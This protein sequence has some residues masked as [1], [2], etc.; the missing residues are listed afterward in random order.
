MTI[1]VPET[2]KAGQESVWD[3]PR[4]AIAQHVSS[5]LKIMHRGIIVAETKK[6]VRT[7]ETSHPPSYYFPRE[8][9]AMGLLSLSN[10]SSFCEWKG[11]AQYLD[12]TVKGE[13]LKNVGWSYPNPTS[14]FMMLQNFIAFYASPF[15]QCLV[16]GEKALPQPGD[17]YGGWVTSKFSGPFKGVA[18]SRFW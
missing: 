13:T 8:D 2:P 14:T 11:N 3:F 12:V 1:P 9:V 15:D 4:P 17:F 6:G 10:N 5:H 7:L 16:D 18:G